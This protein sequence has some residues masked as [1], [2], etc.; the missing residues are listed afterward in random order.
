MES[1]TPDRLGEIYESIQPRMAATKRGYLR[2][3]F[4]AALAAAGF[5]MYL[6]ARQ[7]ARQKRFAEDLPETLQ[8]IAGSLRGGSS[9]IQ[10]IQT[11]ADEADATST[12][13]SSVCGALELAPGERDVSG[14]A[15]IS[16][17]S[18]SLSGAASDG[19]RLVGWKEGTGRT[20]SLPGVSCGH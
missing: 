1:Q 6:A 10:A 9:M 3:R 19:T 8:L 18:S 12:C 20:S 14:G 4:G 7:S 15:S 16:L 17:S 13:S 2:T 11:V 5:W